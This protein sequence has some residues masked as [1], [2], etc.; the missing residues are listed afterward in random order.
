MFRPLYLSTGLPVTEKPSWENADVKFQV[1]LELPL[2]RNIKGSG[3][4]VL[5]AYTQISLWNFYAHSSPFY[6][7]TYIPG[8]YA[9]K[10]WKE[11]DGFPLRTLI[12]GAEHRSNGR[13]DEYSR[14]LNYGLISYARSWR[15]GLVLQANLHIGPGWY[16]DKLG[17]DLPLKYYGLLQMSATYTTPSKGW[18]FLVSAS[19]LY[20]SS[21]ANVTAEIARRIGS[22]HNNPYFFVQFHY[23]YDEAFRECIDSYGPLILEDGTV[24][25]YGGKPVPPRAMLRFGIL[26]TPHSVMRG[27]L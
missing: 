16:G 14:S 3:I 20:N 9:R 25:Y 11:D 19:P 2:W 27:N 21:I 4:D 22:K 23:G 8:L 10:V 1:S 15:S 17:W 12:I 18:E 26:I 24:P 7:N 13:D 6:D 5:V